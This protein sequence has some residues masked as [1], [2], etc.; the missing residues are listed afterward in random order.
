MIA[1]QGCAAKHR[2]SGEA[3]G[4][5]PGLQG[6]IAYEVLPEPRPATPVLSARQVFMAPDPLDTPLP[7]YPA[8]AITKGARPVTVMVRIII[9]EDG[10]VH[11]VLDSPREQRREGDDHVVFRQAV[12]EAVRNWKYRP[13]TI[14][15][16]AE[17]EDINNDGNADNTELIEEKA[18][19]TYLDLL[20]TFEVVNGRA[21][22]RVAPPE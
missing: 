1:G 18:V 6:R 2:P 17:G 4:G 5:G 3:A 19:R 12:K 8:G 7:D 11:Q 9:H 16:Y 14:R 20:F 15:T 22:V 21:R 13:A 10:A